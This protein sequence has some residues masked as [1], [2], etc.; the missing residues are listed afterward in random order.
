MKATVIAK[1]GT[2]IGCRTALSLLQQEHLNLS[3]YSKKL[4]IRL[5]RW[6]VQ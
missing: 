4:L 5:S 2:I 1:P 6:V 3:V